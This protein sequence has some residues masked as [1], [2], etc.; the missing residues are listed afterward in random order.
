MNKYCKDEI[1]CQSNHGLADSEESAAR[2]YGELTCDIPYT[3]AE[4]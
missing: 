1:C 2:K 4:K 3:A